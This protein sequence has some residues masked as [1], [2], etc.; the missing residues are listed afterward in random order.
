MD[1]SVKLGQCNTGNWLPRMAQGARCSLLDYRE[2][3]LREV[4]AD[5]IP[6]S[7]SS[8]QTISY[9]LGW[10]ETTSVFSLFLLEQR[11][12]CPENTR[13]S[14]ADFAYASVHRMP[15]AHAASV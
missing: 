11:R 5:E 8:S 12:R 9:P 2:A 4:H 15:P 10:K 6:V 13:R 14:S 7:A 1:A 3:G